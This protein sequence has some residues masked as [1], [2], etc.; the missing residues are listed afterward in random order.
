MADDRD[1]LER[2]YEALLKSYG[3]IMIAQAATD[4]T[5]E[6]RTQETQR[7]RQRVERELEAKAA[8]K[9]LADLE[10]D[11]AKKADATTV[12]DVVEELRG[13]RKLLVYLLVSICLA[14]F[15]FGIAALQIAG[16]H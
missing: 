1:R 8:A 3:D 13:I 15:G 11:V 5:I 12:A 6:E 10:L 9:D 14:S 16:S 4:R 2:H 7:Y